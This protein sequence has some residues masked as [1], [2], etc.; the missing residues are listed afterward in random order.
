M[1]TVRTVSHVCGNFSLSDTC[2]RTDNDSV[3]T[4]AAAAWNENKKKSSVMSRCARREKKVFHSQDL[5]MTPV[6]A[7]RMEVDYT[8]AAQ[9]R[10]PR[11]EKFRLVLVSVTLFHSVVSR[12]ASTM[13][14][15]LRKCRERLSQLFVSS[16]YSSTSP[17][18]DIKSTKWHTCVIFN[19]LSRRA[20]NM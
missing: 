14:L 2:L 5:L 19:L 7:M 13:S 15:R 12:F 11:C 16:F 18:T 6:A 10:E 4:F 1:E 8:K 9:W 17:K 20:V 3:R